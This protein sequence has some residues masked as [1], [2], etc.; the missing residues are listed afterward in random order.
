MALTA[1]EF[2]KEFGQLIRSIEEETTPF[3][4]NTSL[5]IARKKRALA[6]PLY[7][8]SV[9]FPHYIDL[10]EEFQRLGLTPDAEVDYV[11]AGFAPFHKGLYVL[12]NTLGTFSIICGFRESAKSTHL[13]K[14]DVVR[15]LVA[16]D[17][18]IMRWFVTI[19]AKTEVK[20]EQ[21]VVPIKIELEHNKRLKQDFGD[22]VGTERWEY[23]AIKLKNGRAC[24]SYS[25]LQ[26]LRGE[27]VDT[28]R[29]D[30]EVFDDISDPTNPD[31]VEIVRKFVDMVKGNYLKAVNATRWSAVY[32]GNNVMKGDITDELLTGKNTGHYHKEIIRALVPNEMETKEDREIARRCR[33]AGFE[34]GWKSAWEYRHP[35]LRLLQERAND[36][37]T[38]DTE[39]MQRARARKGQKFQD[40]YFRYHTRS[41][42]ARGN[43]IFYSAVDPSAKDAGDYKATIT[44]GV[45]LRPDGE[46]MHIPVVKA[47]IKQQTVDEMLKE[48]YEQN[49][50]YHP[51]MFGVEMIGFAILLEREYRRLA[52]KYGLLPFHKVDTKNESK[53]S[54]IERLVDY[55]KDGIITFDLEDP[56]Q[57][58]LI[59]QLKAF[60][61]GGEVSRGGVGDDGPD[62][63]EMCIRMIERFPPWGEYKY[64][65]VERREMRFVRDDESIQV[66]AY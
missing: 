8:A 46:T 62:A 42:I 16:D 53:E 29:P 1:K 48:G 24:Y 35:T 57:E 43:Y 49:R 63:L 9:Y 5:Q 20:A 7:F 13:G 31:S 22:L 55:V 60:P 61:N 10:P 54:R 4:K 3:P 41:E 47:S 14:I 12:A 30:H 56:D 39:M 65:T 2:D 50:K 27:E 17:R 19:I 34:T 52:K 32:L 51:K 44:V 26:G 11:R 45:G 37:D 6:D 38:F 36:P 25:R 15:K 33:E 21:K 58:L 40:A 18:A 59:Q 64:E 23:G 28:H 66:G